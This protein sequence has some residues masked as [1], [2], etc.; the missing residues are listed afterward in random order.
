MLVTL[1]LLLALGAIF[2]KGFRE[3]ITLAVGLVAVYLALNVVII[4]DGLQDIL[5]PSRA[6][7]DLEARR[8][9]RSTATR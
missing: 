1:V 2:L 8:S 5:P 7:R 9:S 6:R 3:A 4:V